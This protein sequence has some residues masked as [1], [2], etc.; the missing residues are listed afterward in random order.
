MKFLTVHIIISFLL[1]VPA[2]APGCS[3]AGTC[4]GKSAVSS[5]SHMKQ[6]RANKC[7]C[8]VGN[9]STHKIPVTAVTAAEHF[10]TRHLASPAGLRRAAF[11]SWS[12]NFPAAEVL[13]VEIDVRVSKSSI[14]VIF[15]VFR[16]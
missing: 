6:M 3:S 5:H 9:C 14:I 7:C 4:C 13:P 1:A 12:K 16:C 11:F 2:A 15:C 8:G 10:E